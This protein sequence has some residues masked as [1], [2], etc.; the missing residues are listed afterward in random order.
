ML[1]QAGASEQGRDLA[2]RVLKETD[3]CGTWRRY[4]RADNGEPIPAFGGWAAL[5]RLEN[6]GLCRRLK[7][8]A[9]V[10]HILPNGVEFFDRWTI[11][12]E[13]RDYREGA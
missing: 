3:I 5:Y 12:P 6:Y 10:K 1:F 11:T 2:M 4:H 7:M 8:P 13:G 9:L